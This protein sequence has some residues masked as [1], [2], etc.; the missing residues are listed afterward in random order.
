MK[1]AARRPRRE[2]SENLVAGGPAGLWFIGADFVWADCRGVGIEQAFTARSETKFDQGARVGDDLGLPSVIGLIFGQG[3]AGLIVPGAAGL[4]VQIMFANQSGLNFT[5][6]FA[7][8]GSLSA[9]A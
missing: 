9:N 3:V 7:A 5:G 6:A 8:G 4:A 1:N 2:T